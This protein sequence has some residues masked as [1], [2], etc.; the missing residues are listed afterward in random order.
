MDAASDCQRALTRARHAFDHVS[1]DDPAAGWFTPTHYERM[2]GS[3]WLSLHRYRDAETALDAVA[4]QAPAASKARAIALGNLALA[5][6][7]QHQLGEATQTLHRAIDVLEAT[8]G[9]GG[10]TLA[11]TTARALRP[12]NQDPRVS[13]VTDRV[14]ALIAS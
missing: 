8:R 5:C 6:L 4:S 7:G 10:L 2:A 13:E 11:F 14:L 12:W 9:G 1:P 3:C